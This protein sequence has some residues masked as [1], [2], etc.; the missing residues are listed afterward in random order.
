MQATSYAFLHSHIHVP[1]H[2]SIYF[3]I[4]P[5]MGSYYKKGFEVSHQDVL[6]DL[7]QVIPSCWEMPSSLEKKKG[8]AERTLAGLGF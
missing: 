7:G 8:G 3:S 6:R 5:F 4:H 1:T 2:A